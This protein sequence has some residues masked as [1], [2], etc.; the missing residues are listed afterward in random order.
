MGTIIIAL[1]IFGVLVIVH[2]FGHF[3]IAKLIGVKVEEFAV[4][5]GPKIFGFQRGETL[6]TLRALPLGGFC[7]MLGEDEESNDEK[8][9]NNKSKWGRAAVFAAGSIMNIIL[10]IL[11]LAI[12]L[13][14]IG[15][16]I[17]TIAEVEKDYPAYQAGIRSGDKILSLNDQEIEKYSQIQ[18]IITN[19][20]DKPLK[21]I[22]ER[23]NQIQQLDL[24][25][26]YDQDL[27]R[28]RV[29]ISPEYEKSIITAMIFSV[30][31]SVL[32]VKAILEV[33]GQLITGKA[34]L[35]NFTGPV[36]VIA[37]VNET[38]KVGILPVI[39]LASQIS[40]NLG[41]FNLLPIPAL[42]GSRLLFLAIEAIRGKP[43][44]PEKEGV[45]HFAG[46]IVLMIFAVFIGYRDII[47]FF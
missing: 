40:L 10:A 31:E 3:S 46:L 23:D 30:E 21:V 20:E 16:P 37:I 35:D 36:G 18:N 42:D 14:F 24:V 33:L 17:T 11:L 34:N 6:Y 4:G 26:K 15:T 22:V 45:F 47:R 9:L 1:L 44:A 41:I 19:N 38:A 5:M 32:L 2:E 43:L 7:S 25:P 8:S 27:E 29:G 28:Y 13:Y 39:L 12:V